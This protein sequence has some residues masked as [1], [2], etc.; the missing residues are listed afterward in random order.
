MLVFLYQ[1]TGYLFVFI[2]I[3]QQLQEEFS[4]SI[5]SEENSGNFHLTKISVP[6]AWVLNPNAHFQLKEKNEFSLDGKMYDFVSTETVGETI[7][8]TCH[9]DEKEERIMADF[10]AHQPNPSNSGKTVSPNKSIKK[11]LK[12][13]ISSFILPG[14]NEKFYSFSQKQN[15]KLLREKY[16]SEFIEINSPPPEIFFS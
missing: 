6:V 12:I 8:F 14:E 10:Q 13:F 11:R 3:H 1:C 9:Q 2:F 5:T 15:F 7:V 4:H 16:K